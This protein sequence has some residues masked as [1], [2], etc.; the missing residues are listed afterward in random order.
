MAIHFVYNGLDN[1]LNVLSN[2]KLYAEQAGFDLLVFSK[3]EYD[4]LRRYE[5]MIERE[6]IRIFEYTPDKQ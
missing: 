3:V 1:F 6:K 2:Q 5:A 4:F